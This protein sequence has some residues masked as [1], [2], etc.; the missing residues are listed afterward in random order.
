MLRGD[1]DQRVSRARRPCARHFSRCGWY[2]VRWADRAQL[3]ALTRGRGVTARR[4]P[5]QHQRNG[6]AGEGS[7]PRTLPSAHRLGGRGVTDDGV[8]ARAFSIDLQRFELAVVRGVPGSVGAGNGSRSRF[9]ATGCGARRRQGSD[10]SGRG[11]RGHGPG[12]GEL[13][14]STRRR[15][16]PTS[17]RWRRSATCL[18]TAPS[19]AMSAPRPQ[20]LRKPPESRRRR[21]AAES[22]RRPAARIGQEGT[23]VSVVTDLSNTASMPP[24]LLTIIGNWLGEPD[25]PLL[26]QHTQDAQP[27]P[28]DCGSSLNAESSTLTT[29]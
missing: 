18:R 2:T 10:S 28:A 14:S 7:P 5:V 20:S 16:R 27:G 3:L 15:R 6:S 4:A 24:R 11:W 13:S 25:E 26:Q 23:R 22:P 12:Q 8:L 1:Q 21:S 29:S 17:R 9:G 19:A